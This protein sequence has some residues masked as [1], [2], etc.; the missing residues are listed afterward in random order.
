MSSSRLAAQHALAGTR[1]QTITVPSAML[2]VESPR[3]YPEEDL[4]WI[5]SV[6]GEK[7]S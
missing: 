6:L 4:I 3:K 5:I 2:L 7:S 1:C